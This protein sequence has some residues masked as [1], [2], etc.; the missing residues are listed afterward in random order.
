MKKLKEM[1]QSR[2]RGSNH[3]EDINYDTIPRQVLAMILMAEAGGNVVHV[4]LHSNRA[5]AI[6][7]SASQICEKLLIP[8]QCRD[9]SLTMRFESSGR[10]TFTTADAHPDNFRGAKLTGVFINEAP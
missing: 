3:V 1:L 6:C 10:I 4:S 8:H 7:R 5:W 2:L 9:P